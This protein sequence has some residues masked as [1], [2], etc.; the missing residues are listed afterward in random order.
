MPPGLPPDSTGEGGEAIDLVTASALLDLVSA[1][2]LVRLVDWCVS[3]RTALLFALT[4]VGHIEWSPAHPGDATMTRAMELDQRRDKGLG[5]ALGSDAVARLRS[6]LA[7]RG[8]LDAAARSDWVLGASGADAGIQRRLID[9]LAGLAMHAGADG[10]LG[11]AWRAARLAALDAGTSSLTVGHVDVAAWAGDRAAD[12]AAR[13][14]LLAPLRSRT[15]ATR[16]PATE[17]PRRASQP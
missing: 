8:Y 15:A 3:R 10:N 5:M 9:D 4:Y 2:W 17:R 12:G 7:A 6:R 16:H 14:S 13:D 1:A 11:S